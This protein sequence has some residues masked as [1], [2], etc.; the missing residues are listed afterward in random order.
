MQTPVDFHAKRRLGSLKSSILSVE[1]TPDAT[2][3]PVSDKGV[4]SDLTEASA[5]VVAVNL[6][7]CR[8]VISMV[9]PIFRS[10]RSATALRV[11]VDVFRTE[12]AWQVRRFAATLDGGS[13]S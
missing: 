12:H 7:L 11:K 10:V 3:T 8:N 1:P 6:H 9:L 2:S 4:A 13:W 5:H